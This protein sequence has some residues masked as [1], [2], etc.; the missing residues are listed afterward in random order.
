VTVPALPVPAED[1]LEL[2]VGP[3][4]HGGH[5]V[6]RHEGRV[7]FVRHALPGE[8]VLA[9]VTEG[10]ARSRFLRADAVQVLA[11]SPDRVPPRCPH[12]RP[13]GCGGCDFQHVAVRA[14]R[15]LKADVVR[16]Q[17]T[18]LA[19][20]GAHPLVRGL[21]VEAVPGDA[22][23]L[24]WR[25]R[26]RLAAAP[27]GRL[28][29]RRHRS[30]ALELLDA[31]P[32][33]HPLVDATGVLGRTWPGVSEVSVAVAPSTGDWVLLAD[34]EPVP[35]HRRERLVERA[36][37]RS[38]R[39]E[40][41]GFWQVHPGAAD[42]LVD[43]VRTALGPRPDE[44]LL[45]LYS[46]VGLFA[47]SLAPD[48]GPGGRVDAV[49]SDARAVRT[50]RRNLHDL[51]RVRL[52]TDRVQAWLRR[53][54]LRR[55][56]LVVLDPPRSGAGRAVVEGLVRLAPRAVA[57]VACDPAALARDVGTFTG[58]GWRLAGLRAFDLFPM[59][60]HVEAVALLEPAPQSAGPL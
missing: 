24:A 31:C 25:T 39:V 15:A 10:T 2:E 14:Q 19:R 60:H 51:P 47:G 50:A 41:T 12:A 8:R 37:G 43:A 18:R 46:G 36:A 30:H 27:D 42:V 20:L 45:D 48:L 5:C 35:P 58:L 32:L 16:E 22:D 49:E 28:G 29:L 34:G 4:A 59:T 26:V 6:A 1:L 57:Y 7:V 52:H 3:V 55:C 56:D 54:A 33:L 17:L 38:W 13:G 11:A 40:G 44:H 53:G 9:Q 23:G 21:Q